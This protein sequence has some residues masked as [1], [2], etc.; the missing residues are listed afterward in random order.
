MSPSPP[1]RETG[2]R[3]RARGV[4]RRRRDRD[5]AQ[6]G[7]ADLMGSASERFKTFMNARSKA[8]AGRG[9]RRLMGE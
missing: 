3:R 1:Y 2:G 4:I 5:A 8:W 6:G 7:G 9:C